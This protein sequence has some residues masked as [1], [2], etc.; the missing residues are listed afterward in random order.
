MEKVLAKFLYPSELKGESRS[1]QAGI[2]IVAEST[3]TKREEECS[4]FFNTTT[5]N[6]KN[7]I[8]N[9]KFF[10]NDIEISEGEINISWQHRHGN[11]NKHIQLYRWQNH[12]DSFNLKPEK[13]LAII[14][15]VDDESFSFYFY[16]Y[17]N[18]HTSY[19]AVYEV[20]Q[21]KGAHFLNY[22]FGV[23]NP[24][25]ELIKTPSVSDI[26][27]NKRNSSNIVANERKAIEKRAEKVTKDEL[28]K[29]DFKLEFSLG[30][31]YD[32]NFTKNKIEYRVEVK[33]TKNPNSVKQINITSGEIFHARKE[34][35]IGYPKN[36]EC[37]IKLCVVNNIKTSMDSGSWEAIGGEIVYFDD[38]IID[39][40]IKKIFKN[41]NIEPK[42][43]IYKF[44]NHKVDFQN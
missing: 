17:T 44:L 16:I 15:D 26:R 31:P 11:Q 8:K 30:K 29:R 28:V 27:E 39:M 25:P 7:N 13:T 6:K 43:F 23:N 20:M 34:H 5:E 36:R 32:L 3:I 33:G 42:A 38:F 40:D 10:F 41:S 18:Q 19:K 9:T 24:M 2:A 21:K 14:R 12:Y 22:T 37:R 1:N 35:E 4:V